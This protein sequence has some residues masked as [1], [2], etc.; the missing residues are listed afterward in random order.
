M[1][2]ASSSVSR[3]KG[4]RGITRRVRDEHGN[5]RVVKYQ[6]KGSRLSI[7]GLTWGKVPSLLL[8]IPLTAYAGLLYSNTKGYLSEDS[9]GKDILGTTDEMSATVRL[10][11]TGT[12]GM[13]L[14]LFVGYSL[15]RKGFKIRKY[16]GATREIVAMWAALI[17]LTA[18]FS[19]FINEPGLIRQQSDDELFSQGEWDNVCENLWLVSLLDKALVYG[20]VELVRHLLKE[21][22]FR[23]DDQGYEEKREM[24]TFLPFFRALY[25]NTCHLDCLKVYKEVSLDDDDRPWYEKLFNVVLALSCLIAVKTRIEMIKENVEPELKVGINGAWR[26]V[27]FQLRIFLLSLIK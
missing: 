12:I 24:F 27:M 16:P 15:I 8:G 10:I 18:I 1:S 11:L 13:V 26:E 25:N 22:V 6:R 23:F 21:K 14:T 7:P 17:V 2:S 4:K 9:L 19:P 20:C 5:I 3:K